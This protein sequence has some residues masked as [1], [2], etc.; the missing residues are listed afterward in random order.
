MYQSIVSLRSEGEL[1]LLPSFTSD[2]VTVRA[3]N[4]I[5]RISKD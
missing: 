4:P 5:D 1:V 2:K 3:P